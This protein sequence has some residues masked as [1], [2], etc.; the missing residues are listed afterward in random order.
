[1]IIPVEPGQRMDGDLAALDSPEKGFLIV[2]AGRHA[3]A[4]RDAVRQARTRAH[5][6][7]VPKGGPED[8]R[9]GADRDA[10]ENALGGGEA[11]RRFSEE[12]TLPVIEVPASLRKRSPCTPAARRRCLAP[13]RVCKM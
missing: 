12:D 4:S 8:P 7:A 9:A 2:G 11:G 13:F 10:A 1:M 6:D 3:A 5:L